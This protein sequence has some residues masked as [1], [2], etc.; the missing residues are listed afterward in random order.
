M[1]DP[2]SVYKEIYKNNF[3]NQKLRGKH[4]IDIVL[5]PLGLKPNRATKYLWKNMFTEL[6]RIYFESKLANKELI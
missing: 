3:S 2:Y 1:D 4:E 6:D 5:N